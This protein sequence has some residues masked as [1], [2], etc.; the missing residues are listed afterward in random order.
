MYEFL[1][2]MWILRR[3]DAAKLQSCVSKG[4]ITADQMTAIT[5]TAQAAQ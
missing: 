2:N 3:A 5:A 4:Y 1:L